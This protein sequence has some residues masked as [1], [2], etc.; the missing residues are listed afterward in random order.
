MN[1]SIAPQQQRADVKL[2]AGLGDIWRVVDSAARRTLDI[3]IAGLGILVLLPVLL[4]LA[5]LWLVLGKPF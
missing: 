1:E 4:L 2:Q 3:L 5:V